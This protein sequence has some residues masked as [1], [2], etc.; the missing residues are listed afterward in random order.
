MAQQVPN[1]QLQ[2]ASLSLRRAS[3]QGNE[4][5]AQH[6]ASGPHSGVSE[7]DRALLDAL[8]TQPRLPSTRD[9]DLRP[10]HHGLMGEVRSERATSDSGNGSRS[11]GANELASS[12]A[13]GGG[14]GGDGAATAGPRVTSMAEKL[15]LAPILARRLERLSHSS[16]SGSS[17]VRGPTWVRACAGQMLSRARACVSVAGAVRALAACNDACP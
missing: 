11:A 13:A 9:V 1:L 7:N 10:H 12:S 17:K 4:A 8:V 2:R 15:K 6:S 3:W 16:G 14:R 5:S